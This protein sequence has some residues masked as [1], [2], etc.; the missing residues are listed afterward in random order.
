MRLKNKSVV[1]FWYPVYNEYSEL[2]LNPIEKKKKKTFYN[3]IHNQP[4]Y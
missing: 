3:I 4:L 1:D 2:S